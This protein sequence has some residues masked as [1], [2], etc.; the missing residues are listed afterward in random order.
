MNDV[1]SQTEIED[2]LIDNRSRAHELV[3]TQLE[4]LKKLAEAKTT[5]KI[6]WSKVYMQN[7]SKGKSQKDSEALAYVACADAYRELNLAEAQ[8]KATQSAVDASEGDRWAIMSLN[9]N[10]RN[11]V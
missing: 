4:V 7:R 8:A 3:D 9:A 1:L 2:K 11:Q 10:V 6:N 5:F